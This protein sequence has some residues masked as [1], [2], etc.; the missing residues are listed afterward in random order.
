MGKKGK[1]WEEKFLLQGWGF[2]NFAQLDTYYI[3]GN[4]F[5]TI[6]PKPDPYL[7]KK[8]SMCYH[9]S[10]YLVPEIIKA[11]FSVVNITYPLFFFQLSVSD[12]KLLLLLHLQI[13]TT[14]LP[15]KS[16][17]ACLHFRCRF[18]MNILKYSFVFKTSNFS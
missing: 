4:F 5:S 9:L 13:C 17:I 15:L 7:W 16:L 11:A 8:K 3:S 14:G 12:L 1:P 6:W 2:G 18:S 10:N